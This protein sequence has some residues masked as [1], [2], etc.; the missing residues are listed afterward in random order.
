MALV[1]SPE[2][3]EAD[4]WAKIQAAHK[5]ALE[6]FEGL[7][8]AQD[9][10]ICART[11][12]LVGRIE[13]DIPPLEVK[14]DVQKLGLATW[15]AEHPPGEPLAPIKV[16]MFEK[17]FDIETWPALG[18]SLSQLLYFGR[19][20][21]KEL[22]IEA[23]VPVLEQLLV[24]IGEIHTRMM[25]ALQ[26]LMCDDSVEPSAEAKAALEA[27]QLAHAKLT[28]A[29]PS[30]QEPW[31]QVGLING[32]CPVDLAGTS[33][34]PLC[35][36]FGARLEKAL[37]YGRR[38]GDHGYGFFIDIYEDH[39]A[40]SCEGRDHALLHVH[41]N[42]A[43]VIC[44]REVGYHDFNLLIH[45]LSGDLTCCTGDVGEPESGR[46]AV[47]L[48]YSITIGKSPHPHKVVTEC[49]RARMQNGDDVGMEKLDAL[50]FDL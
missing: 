17:T 39:L 16:G 8:G 33:N 1:Q 24:A 44:L 28:R 4:L 42:A 12:S 35:Y 25:P 50:C 32:P 48:A 49:V 9:Q 38:F 37:P 2:E 26:T 23:L 29:F 20:V 6:S 46:L 36:I 11:E 10:V 43:T 7:M 19:Q 34:K 41:I 27:C 45:A 5:L 13:T 30:P 31:L 15:M 22:R 21:Q 47:A 18:A 3:R 14:V 40:L